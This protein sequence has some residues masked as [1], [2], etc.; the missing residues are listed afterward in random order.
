[1]TE[2]EKML[3]GALYDAGEPELAAARKRAKEICQRFN[4]T[5]VQDPEGGT[6]LLR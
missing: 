5:A 6:A 2:Q 1:M 4:Q 3:A